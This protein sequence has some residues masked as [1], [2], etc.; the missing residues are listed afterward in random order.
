[1]VHGITMN[2]FDIV[3]FVHLR[4][5]LNRLL[6]AFIAYANFTYSTSN[7]AAVCLIH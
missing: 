7:K 2:L 3:L 4:A 1:M 5:E 6:S